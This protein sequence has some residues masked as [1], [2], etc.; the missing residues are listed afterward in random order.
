MKIVFED[1]PSNLLLL[2]TQTVPSFKQQSQ[3]LRMQVKVRLR[4]LKSSWYCTCTD[5]IAIMLAIQQFWPGHLHHY[6]VL[7]SIFC[8]V[9][10]LSNFKDH[11][12]QRMPFS[13]FYQM[14]DVGYGNNIKR[15]KLK[16]LYS[17]PYKSNGFSKWYQ[18]KNRS[19]K[20]T[21][22]C[23]GYSFF[24][25][26]VLNYFLKKYSSIQ[27]MFFCFIRNSHSI[28]QVNMWNIRRFH[29]QSLCRTFPTKVAG[30]RDQ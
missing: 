18:K 28:S 2:I 25:K 1:L 23:F 10:F 6:Y 20:G 12:F 3:Q 4:S 29:C 9:K 11:L 21:S 8:T 5:I 14:Q 16:R 30:G 27:R 13:V 17:I 19:P 24:K 15:V 7:V 26:G 22:V